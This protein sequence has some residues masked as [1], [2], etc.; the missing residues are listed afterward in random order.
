VFNCAISLSRCGIPVIFIS[1]LGNDN[2]GKTM[3]DFMK[4]NRL[5]TNYIYTFPDGVSPVSIAFLDE[6][7]NAEYQ[8]FTDYPE[9]R[10]QIEFPEIAKDD[11]LIVGSYF[12]VN[13]TLR[14]KIAELLQKASENK[15]II[16]YDVNFRKSHSGEREI[17]TPF[18]IENFKYADIIRCS[19]E[20]LENLFPDADPEMAY[21]SHIKPYCDIFILTRGEKSVTLNT[22]NLKKDYQVDKVK[23]ISTIGAGDNFNAGI[24]YGIMKEN[25]A[26]GELKSLPETTWDKL[27]NYGKRFAR[28]VCTT[29]DNYVRKGFLMILSLLLPFLSYA[30]NNTT[31]TPDSVVAL[32]NKQLLEYPMEKIHVQTDKSFYLSGET[33]WF[34]IFLND[35]LT[36]LPDTT[37]RYV[38]A[39]LINPLDE[40]VLRAKIHPHNGVYS[41]YFALPEDIAE[42]NYQIR[43]YTFFMEGRGEDWFFKK[44]IQ[45]GDPLSGL[46]FT[47][48]E[49]SKDDKEKRIN[50]EFQFIKR[51]NGEVFLPEK[52]RIMDKNGVMKQVKPD[53]DSLLRQSFN[54]SDLKKSLVYIEYDF[55]DKFHKE[56]IPIELQND[57]FDLAFFPEGG[58]IPSGAHVK[59]GFKALNSSGLSEEISGKIINEKEDTV[60]DFRTQHAGMGEFILYAF[61]GEKYKAVC[62]NSKGIERIFNLPEATDSVVSLSVVTLRDKLTISLKK[63]ASGYL[64]PSPLY[65]IIHTRGIILSFFEWNKEKEFVTVDKTDFPSGITHILLTDAAFRPISERLS[66]LINEND[67]AKTGFSTDRESYGTRE[68]VMTQLSVFNADN[69]PLNGNF[70]VSITDDKDL[71]PDSTIN[72]LSTMLLTSELKGYI[73]DP[74]YYFRNIDNLTKYHLDELMLTQGWRRYDIP[75]LLRGEIQ[76]PKGFLE[77][78]SVISGVVR[79]GI[80]MTTPVKNYPVTIIGQTFQGQLFSGENGRFMQPVPDFP[81]SSRFIVQALTKKGGKRVELLLDSVIYPRPV[82]GIPL[83]RNDNNAFLSDYI[84]KADLKYTYENGMRTIYLKEVV[85]SAQKIDKK[86]KSTYSSSFNT[87]LS[88]EDIEKWHPQTIFDILRTV[89]GVNV[90]GETVSIRGGGTPLFMIDDF[91]VEA[92]LISSLVMDDIDEIEVVKGPQAAIF[93]SRGANGAILITTKRGFDQTVNRSPQWNIKSLIPLGYQNPKEFYSPKYETPDEKSSQIPDL[94]STIYW[95]PNVKIVDG[96]AEISFYTADGAS[97]YTAV[98]EGISD[99]G[100]LIYC[101]ETIKIE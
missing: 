36:N 79:G 73:E 100:K 43:F 8:F 1:E 20:D 13:P 63:P 71:Q 56:F 84:E 51:E 90:S 45:I 3:S 99:N 80:M 93:G 16:Y 76:H 62:R 38:Y 65:I 68:K 95:N 24:I 49:F 32:F 54:I 74:A 96:K 41:G 55:N 5:N 82:F 64:P 39:E 4:D 85:V 83:K 94:R 42:G 26:L 18:F 92:D 87:I 91:S 21:N 69:E 46:Y 78:G 53:K 12:A 86:G 52:I 35:A 37:S 59:M 61:A 10:L 14:P 89:A 29:T 6:K 25:I 70:A 33:V 48:A 40:L 17:L 98:I 50:A 72:I 7:G 60:V 81:D 11:L 23:S 97:D 67:I 34:R 101:R 2:V 58:Q 88:S 31:I 57:D 22:P 77:L 47:K 75:A 44:K 15:A 30:Q 27:I 28:E 66:F 9:K 19:N